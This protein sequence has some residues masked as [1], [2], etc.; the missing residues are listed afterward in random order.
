LRR[1]LAKKEVY[2]MPLLDPHSYYDSSQARTRHARISWFVDFERRLLDGKV[3]LEFEQP[4]HGVLDLDSKALTVKSARTKYGAEIPF[5]IGAHDEILGERLRLNLPSPTSEVTIEYATSPEAVALQW[6]E[7]AQTEG[8]KHPF[9]YSQCQAIHARTIA[10]LQDTPHCRISYTAEVTVPEELAAVMSAGPAGERKGDKPGTKTFL[11]EMPQPIPPYLLALAAGNLRERD[12]STR[13]RV[14]A[15][16]ETLDRA[17]WEFAGIEEM[18]RT[19]EELFGPYEWDRYD[20]LV[21]PP[22]FPYGGMEN[23]RM[24][25]LTPTIIAGDRS[26]VDVVGHELAHSWTGNLV[27]NASMEHFWLNE[28]AT[29][30]AERRILEALHGKDAAVLSWAIGQKALDGSIERF[31]ADSPLTALRTRLEGIDPDDAFSSVP[32][33]K[34]ARLL[35]AIE[36]SVGRERFDCFVR[37]YITRFR[38]TSITTEEFMD[39]LEKKLPGAAAAVDARKWLDEP[40]MPANAPVFVSPRLEQIVAAA[41]AFGGGQRP[42]D[43]EIAGWNPA[44]TLIFLQ[45]LPR[46]LDSESLAWLDSKLKLTGRGN[47]EILVEWLTIAAGSDYEPVF[48]KIREVL[49]R[50][51]RMKYLR[52]LFLAMGRHERTRALG[53]EIYSGVKPTYHSLSQ[54]VVESVMAKWEE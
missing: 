36:R 9:L 28:G 18:I 2:C 33:E 47:Y 20:M 12:L 46:E 44:E 51:G 38:F 14:W 26:L 40:G 43:A 21:L 48:P 27:T 17:G 30:W 5:E 23:P 25:F 16:P 13:S 22:S 15:E 42:S 34:G 45:N 41:E 10:P 31:G 19:A 39:F 54:R 11:F 52:P 7:P 37:D 49:S 50:V 24:T 32:Y 4:A 3:T 29:T 6:L 35:A 1:N 8:K 53:R